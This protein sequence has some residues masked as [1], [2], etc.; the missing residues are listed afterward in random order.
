ML[1]RVLIVPVLV[2]ALLALVVPPAEASPPSNTWCSNVCP[3]APC[4]T[5]CWAY[6]LLEGKWYW[7]NCYAYDTLF[8][9]GGSC[10]S[11]IGSPTGD[12]DLEHFLA[13][14]ESLAEDDTTIETR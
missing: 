5:Q 1:Q 10:G 4:S 3:T 13:S 8:Y 7:V 9:G 14:L 2:F 6:S 11:A 12:L